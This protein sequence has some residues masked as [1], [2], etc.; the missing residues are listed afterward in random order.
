MSNL[1]WTVLMLLAVCGTAC[2]EALQPPDRIA[3]V[4]HLVGEASVQTAGTQA[5]D[6]AIPNWPMTSGDRLFTAPDARAELSFGIATIRMDE[7]TSL[8]LMKIEQDVTRI[9][10]ESGNVS[11][12]LRAIQPSEDF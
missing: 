9:Q 10:L 5:F 4:S 12:E 7:K 6:A 2:G 3:R 8:V 11:I 1:L